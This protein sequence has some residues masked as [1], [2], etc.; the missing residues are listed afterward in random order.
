MAWPGTV[1]IVDDDPDVRRALERLLHAESYVTRAFGSALDFL[2][3]HEPEQAGCIILDV[4]MPGLDGLQLQQHLAAAGLRRPIIFISGRSDIPKSVR[5]MKAG[6]VNFLTK[7][8][9]AGELLAA[10]REALAVDA[11]RRAE[12]SSRDAAAA[13]LATLTRRERQVLEKVIAGRLNKQ[14][15]AELGTVE[16][17]IKV[18]RSRVMRKMRAGS[19][20]ELVQLAQLAGVVV[21]QGPMVPQYQRR[22]LAEGLTRR[23]SCRN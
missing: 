22:N 20:P 16:K 17:T 1:F 5:A 14:I 21:D 23:S 10:V 12:C 3:Q 15:A 19:L 13:L 11:A 18:H 9:D 7:P 2:T 6:A 8:V 4:A